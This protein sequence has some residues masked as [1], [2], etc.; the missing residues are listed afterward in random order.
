MD[1]ITDYEIFLDK[2]SILFGW[3]NY[4]VNQIF[5]NRIVKIFSLNHTLLSYICLVN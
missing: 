3:S 5:F 4:L 1:E 2:Y